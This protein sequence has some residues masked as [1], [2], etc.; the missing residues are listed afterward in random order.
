MGTRKGREL[1]ANRFPASFLAFSFKRYVFV[2]GQLLNFRVILEFRFAGIYIAG[3]RNY[4]QTGK[5]A[6]NKVNILRLLD[7]ISNVV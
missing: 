5:N 4:S 2:K 7:Y 3:N 6:S 1:T